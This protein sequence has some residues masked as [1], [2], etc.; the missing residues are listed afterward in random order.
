[1][2]ELATSTGRPVI[3][4][5]PAVPGSVPLIRTVTERFLLDADWNLDD[6]ADLVL[7][8]DELGT[9]LVTGAEAGSRIELSI[10]SGRHAVVGR[11]S[12]RLTPGQAVNTTGFGWRV[13]ETVTDSVSIDVGTDHGAATTTV[14]FVKRR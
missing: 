1:M 3:L 13:V 8:V 4:S 9:Q 2:A 11:L 5:V 7:G 12:A 10:S 14:T 6:V